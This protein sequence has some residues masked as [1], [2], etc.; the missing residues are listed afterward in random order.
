M[1]NDDAFDKFLLVELN[2]GHIILLVN[3]HHM[4]HR[5]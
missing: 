4:Y 2:R 5:T 3:I 1:M